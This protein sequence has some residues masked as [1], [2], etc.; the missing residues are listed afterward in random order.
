[1]RR[2]LEEGTLVRST[3]EGMSFYMRRLR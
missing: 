3:Y 2:L 1:V